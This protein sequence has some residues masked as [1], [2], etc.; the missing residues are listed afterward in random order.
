[1]GREPLSIVQEYLQAS[2]PEIR[3]RAVRALA[4]LAGEERLTR[5]VAVALGDQEPKVREEAERKLIALEGEP[6]K[7]AVEALHGTLDREPEAAGDELAERQYRANLLLGRLRSTA[8]LDRSPRR[9]LGRRLQLARGTR[10]YLAGLPETAD[11]R[12]AVWMSAFGGTCGAALLTAGTWTLDRTTSQEVLGAIFVIGLV[13]SPLMALAVAWRA[14]AVDRYFDRPAGRLAEVI[15]SAF[16]SLFGISAVTL[17][18][19]LAWPQVTE[20]SV[21]RIGLLGLTSILAGVLFVASVRIGTAAGYRAVTG[22]RW[23]ACA[24]SA[25][26]GWASGHVP[27]TLL[28]VLVGLLPESRANAETE[29]V[30]AGLWLT[31]M[32]MGLG[33]ASALAQVERSAPGNARRPAQVVVALLLVCFLAWGSWV[34]LHPEPNLS[35]MPGLEASASS[36]T[37]IDDQGR[38]ES[39]LR[40]LYF[41][42]AR[43]W[44]QRITGAGSYGV[45]PPVAAS[46]LPAASRSGRPPAIPEATR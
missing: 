28:L 35:R 18:T 41:E 40:R 37:V 30:V 33:L 8:R 32:P 22:R 29:T 9:S 26:T 21:R 42:A 4:V 11:R 38:F 17:I 16:D 19:L 2:S 36:G 5:L 6:R 13:L 24:V 15:G 14:S 7:I 20:A 25:A 34:V 46:W 45:P 44:A 27:L 12:R 1:M 3:K 31:L 10:S 23:Y 43:R 39:Q